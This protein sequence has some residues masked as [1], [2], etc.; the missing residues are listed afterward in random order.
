MLRAWALSDPGDA[1]VGIVELRRG[2]EA[3]EATGARML[4]H[5]FLVLLAEAHGR[6][7]QHDEALAALEE[8]EA[9]MQAVGERFYE[10]EIYR[11]RAELLHESSTERSDEVKAAL[12]Q[13][14]A[15][16][17]SQQAASLELRTATT[18]RRFGASG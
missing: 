12:R 4:R 3:L 17:K 5:F 2:L 13:S 7:H 14:L 9:E 18:L 10:A 6:A 16:A 8:A 15:V 1:Q 11:L